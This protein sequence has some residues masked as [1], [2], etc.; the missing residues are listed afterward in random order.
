[1]ANLKDDAS[2]DVDALAGKLIDQMTRECAALRKAR[3]EK[4]KK[5]ADAAAKSGKDEKDEKAKKKDKPAADPAVITFRIDKV[6][7]MSRTP[8]EQAALVVKGTSWVCWGAHMADKARDIL[9][10]ADGKYVT[11]SPDKVLG[12]DFDAFK[13]AWLS[14]R[15]GLGLKDAGGKD[16]WVDSDPFHVELSDAKLKDGDERIAACMD[17]YARLSRK[18]DKGRNDKFESKYAKELKPY[19][20]KYT[21]KEDKKK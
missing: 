21:P 9:M 20:D 7:G 10:F 12:D 13:K 2:T 1:M 18:E 8:A 17:E 16:N 4:T 11:S 15:K 3:I 19:L 5:D 6:N 14:N